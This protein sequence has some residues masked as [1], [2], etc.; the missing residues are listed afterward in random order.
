M[1]STRL[2]S[3]LAILGVMVLCLGSL[4]GCWGGGDDDDDDD[5]DDDDDDDDDDS[6]QDDDSAPQTAQLVI[7]PYPF[8]Q[9]DAFRVDQDQVEDLATEYCFEHSEPSSE[10]FF[11]GWLPMRSFDRLFAPGTSKTDNKTLLGNL[12]LSGFFGGVWLKP[13]LFPATPGDDSS[14]K[15]S[16]DN[17]KWI[18]DLLVSQ[19][20][21]QTRIARDGT[22][23]D[24]LAAA[25]NHIYVLIYIYAYNRGY[26]E[27]IIAHPPSGTPFLEDWLVC[28]DEQLLDC[29]SAQ[30][31]FPF[32]DRYNSA[33]DKLLVM[34]NARWE[35]MASL[36][37][38]AT[39]FVDQGAGVWE[40][41]D[42]SM[43]SENDYRLLVGLS[44][45]FLLASKVSVLGNMTAWADE[46]PAQ[47]RYSLMIDSGMLLW[48]GSYVMGLLPSTG[49]QL[50]ELICPDS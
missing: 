5:V 38:N 22:D 13:V 12:Y 42:I 21:R 6:V 30:V 36:A 18:F 45:N 49:D 2:V 47:G 24:V 37:H 40:V 17:L 4:F 50:P 20:G 32:L 14:L 19:T 10:D 11:F 15:G 41:I 8:W 25:H 7:P 23:E 46:Q 29:T 33:L 27:Q 43:M 16:F 3:P 31:V 34:P 35:Q 39:W 44:L 1:S 48:A 28:Q 9:N 26:L